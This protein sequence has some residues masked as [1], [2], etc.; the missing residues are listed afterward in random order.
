MVIPVNPKN[1]N[2]EREYR[3]ARHGGY[4]ASPGPRSPATHLQLATDRLRGWGAGRDGHVA[5][6]RGSA[7]AQRG[8]LITRGGRRGSA[9]DHA[10]RAVLGCPGQPAACRQTAVLRGGW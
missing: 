5:G 1:S 9:G 2:N 10:R 7:A 6:N 3:S 8:D 4:L